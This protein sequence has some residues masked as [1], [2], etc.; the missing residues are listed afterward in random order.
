MDSLSIDTIC[1]HLNTCWN[2]HKKQIRFWSLSSEII[3]LQD[4]YQIQ[5]LVYGYILCK[6]KKKKF[7]VVKICE[8]CGS[9]SCKWSSPSLHLG[10]PVFHTPL[11]LNVAFKKMPWT[12]PLYQV[13]SQESISLFH[14]VQ[15]Y[16]NLFRVPL[17]FMIM[18]VSWKC[19]WTLRLWRVWYVVPFVNSSSFFLL[20][21]K[22][23]GSSWVLQRISSRW[24]KLRWIFSVLLQ[25]VLSSAN[26]W[27]CW[28]RNLRS[29][30]GFI[31]LQANLI[32]DRCI[33]APSNTCQ[34][35]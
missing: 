18:Q 20:H 10:V 1:W 27:A 21:I 29:R 12:F 16:S 24:V 35:N 3:S 22:D 17:L 28:N 9:A 25:T 13:S 6:S 4:L 31:A 14:H 23:E 30:L 7:K 5:D 34:N 8:I 33:L 19:Y 11:I 32:G 26:Q 15:V 2:Q